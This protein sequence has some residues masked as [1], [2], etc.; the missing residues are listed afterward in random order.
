MRL[1]DEQIARARARTDIYAKA[2]TLRPHGSWLTGRCPLH[3]DSKPSFG[4]KNGRWTC[5]SGCGGGDPIAFLQ[6]WHGLSFEEAVRELTDDGPLRGTPVAPVQGAPRREEDTTAVRDILR[7]CEPITPTT[8]AHLYLWSRNLPTRQPGLLAHRGLMCVE[9]RRPLPA[10]VA[11]ISDAEGNVTA[12]QRI[13]CRSSFDSDE[14]D[15]RALL[16]TRR[17]SLGSMGRGAVQLSR[18][19][20]ILG[21]AEGVEKAIA[22]SAMFGVPV[23][24]SCGAQRMARLDLPPIAEKVLLFADNDDAGRAAA[25]DAVDAYRPRRIVPMFPEPR[26]KDWEDQYRE[27]A[28]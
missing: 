22:A 17:K 8:A 28:S 10:L 6:R 15:G 24:A 7:G 18:P 14:K 19:G 11:P 16:E 20:P 21:I 13:W 26:F 4:I 9:Q 1:S 2:T 12:L 23:W 5:F 3:D 27:Q 25:R